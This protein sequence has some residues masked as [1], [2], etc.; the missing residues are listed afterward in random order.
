MVL[1]SESLF[2]R[3]RAEEALREGE[4]KYR[5][6]L[7]NMQEGYYELDPDGTFAFF[8]DALCRILG[9]SEEE[10]RGMNYRDYLPP[11]MRP[12]TMPTPSST[13]STRQAARP[14]CRTGGSSERTAPKPSSRCPPPSWSAPMGRPTGF[15]GIV[16]D[17][18]E[19]HK[20]EQ[21]LREAEARYREL[22]ENANDIIYT[23][24][25]E[26]RF[27]SLNRAGERI[28]GYTHEESRSITAEQIVTPEYRDLVRT[29]VARKLG[30]EIPTRYE[31]E[32]LAKDGHAHPRR[33]QHT[34][35]LQGR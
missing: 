25:L 35:H 34:P 20:T 16:R 10:L 7:E 33:S 30:G 24:D 12:P 9:Y 31:V 6:I 18:T 2:T 28:S 5:E 11:M 17:V 4:R 1:E 29:M 27:T 15:R 32:M 8:N 3:L 21:A 23:H 22:F 19:R 14:S 13:G 26:G